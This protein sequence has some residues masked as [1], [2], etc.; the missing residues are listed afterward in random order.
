MEKAIK[1]AIE[2]GWNK[3]D[4]WHDNP[5]TEVFC[6]DGLCGTRLGAHED[7]KL[8]E[9]IVLDPLFWQSLG[10]G[11]GWKPLGAD[12][13]GNDNWLYYW[14]RF[15]DHLASGKDIDSF[16]TNLMK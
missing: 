1:I 16:F 13:D 6:A 14:H 8:P 11:L 15:I 12:G 9:E 2:N 10:K 3:L 5:K 4:T 7:H